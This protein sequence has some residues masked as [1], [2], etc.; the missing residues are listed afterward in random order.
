M[1]VVLVLAGTA[2]LLSHLGL[3]HG[4]DAW[5]FW[6]VIPALAG[7]FRLFRSRTWAGRAWG[8]LLLGGGALAQ[9]HMLG[10]VRLEWGLVWPI[11]IIA[12]GLLILL[13]S[14]ARRRRTTPAVST[15]QLDIRVVFGGRQERIDSKAFVGG[16]ISC[17]M[18]GCELDLR[19]ARM[20]EASATINVRTVM[21]GVEIYVPRD[22]SVS[23]RGTPIM[24]AFE[25]KT[26]PS[27]GDGPL[28]VIEGS[29]LMGG[30]EIRN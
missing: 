3:L 26:R 16:D 12:A 5:D 18:G 29:A 2:V 15:D 30:V 21:G 20:K 25:D 6:P 22:W 11:G 23:M 27:I 13:S 24:G 4:H 9:L 19:E 10:V 17:T 8:L 1:G 14:L 28:L 7:V